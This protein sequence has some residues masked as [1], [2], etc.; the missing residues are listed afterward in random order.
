M[1]KKRRQSGFTLVELMVALMVTSIVLSAV[2][3][4]AYATSSAK[5]TTDEMGREQAQF[6]HVSMRLTD[7]IKRANRIYRSGFGTNFAFEWGVRLCYDL[8][9]DGDYS[10]DDEMIWIYRYNNSIRV[11]RPSET[12]PEIYTQCTN[13]TFQY[14]WEDGQP[15][16][17][18]IWF[19]M[20]DNGQTQR[21]SINANLWV[22][23]DY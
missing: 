13:P 3:T 11:F 17:V 21:Y 12:S 20:N 8:N 22:S 7:L 19:D 18:A 15:R 2:A 16:T 23:D 4:L 9:A 5:E 1:V 14:R 6:R 10:D